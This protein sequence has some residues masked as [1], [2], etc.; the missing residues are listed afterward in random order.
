MKH[1]LPNE[2]HSFTEKGSVDMKIDKSRLPYMA[3]PLAAAIENVMFIARVK[4]NLDTFSVNGDPVS[5][6]KIN[7]EWKLWR[8]DN[9]DIKID[10]SF[11]LSVA[12]TQ[13]GNLEELMLVVKY[14]I[15]EVLMA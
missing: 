15:R 10:T 11:N 7:D 6:S 2:W 5:L 12:Q 8:G 13:L 9:T 14:T 4:N 1:D 3:Q